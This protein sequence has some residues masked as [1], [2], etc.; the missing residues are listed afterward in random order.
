[1]TASDRKLRSAASDR[2]GAQDQICLA[3]IVTFLLAH[4]YCVFTLLPPEEIVKN[5][6]IYGA[7]HPAHAH[8]VYVYRHALFN[9]YAPWGYDPSTC[10]G[11]VMRP[12]QDAGAKPQQSL[13]ALLPGISEG[14]IIRWFLLL[15]SLLAPAWILL[16]CRLLNLSLPEMAWALLCV[17][18]PIWL[19]QNFTGFLRWGL[20]AFAFASFL[21]PLVLAA[22]QVFLE[23]PTWK[24][25]ISFVVLLSFQAWLHVLGPVLLAPVIL[26]QILRGAGLTTKW[27]VAAVFAPILATV[28]NGFWLVPFLLDF[29]LT[30]KQPGRAF[31][32][33]PA[34]LV[35]HSWAHLWNMLS[36]TRIVLALGA[37][38]LVVVGFRPF[39]GL[40]GR[41]TA[42]AFLIAGLLG[43]LLKFTGS[44][45]PVVVAMQPS[46]FLLTGAM[47]LAIP[48]A[49]GADRCCKILRIPT[50]LG[51]AAA[52][53][54]AVAFAA[55]KGAAPGVE[56]HGQTH[57]NFAGN[58]EM[59]TTGTFGLPYPVPTPSFVDPLTDFVAEHTLP[60]ERILLQTKAQCEGKILSVIW[61]RE[62]VGNAYPDQHDSANF[63]ANKL[64]GREIDDWNPS[65]L[66]ETLAQW[67]INWVIT[68]TESARQLFQKMYPESCHVVGSLHAFHI[69]RSTDRLLIGS[70]KVVASINYFAIS[71]IDAENGVIVLRYRFHP[72]WRS[73]DGSQISPFPVL[74]EPAGFIAI[75]PVSNKV[76]LHFSP[77]PARTLGHLGKLGRVA[78]G[79]GIV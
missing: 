9:G 19:Y 77:G 28:A 55:W 69:S 56:F 51:C 5:S 7:D 22:F 79:R 24:R 31:N 26:V 39:A 48:V 20:A 3:L 4:L 10:A 14:R 62:V 21:G 72:A 65:L 13:G 46:R 44:F 78:P 73:N 43:V 17:L 76:E 23:R 33:Y 2:D 47:L 59:E 68:S 8:R 52:A 41:R 50:A 1:M 6:P 64:F 42:A 61:G 71:D 12:T 38:A 37:I 75:R 40:C 53:V 34:D 58:V 25:Y 35:Y 54:L 11:V 66:R 74:G 15:T 30:P 67:G 29:T 27:R 70:G 63:V 57:V 18:V 60:G 49:L 32:T 16:A 45:I 36:P